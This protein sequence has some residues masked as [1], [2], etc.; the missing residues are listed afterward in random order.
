[1]LSYY[2]STVTL[3]AEGDV[4]VSNDT[5]E[6]LGRHQFPFSFFGVLSTIIGS[7]RSKPPRKFGSPLNEASTPSL[8]TDPR[9]YSF[10]W[11]P[12]DETLEN[13]DQST[14]SIEDQFS[15]K[16]GMLTDML[17]DKGYFLAGGIAGVVSRT[18][19]APLDRL[20][21]YLIAQT[22]SMKD[23]TMHAVKEGAPVQAAK[24]VTRPLA[25]AAK[26]L[27]RMGGIK[28]MFAGEPFPF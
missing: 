10:P 26:A 4:H 27:W 7:P 6:G 18:A 25:Q 28:S 16:G 11:D 17:P 20:K 2:S 3:N 8:A 19:T 9:P 15:Q 12:G 13:T 22:G 23:E 24:R 21:V 5:I 1:M 14:E